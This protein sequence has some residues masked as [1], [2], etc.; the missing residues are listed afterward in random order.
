MIFNFKGL[1]LT[2][3]EF[4]GPFMIF[5]QVLSDQG[6]VLPIYETWG[7]ETANYANF[8]CFSFVFAYFVFETYKTHL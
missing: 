8:V 5:L 4:Q 2:T 3:Y 6:L 7:T 1:F